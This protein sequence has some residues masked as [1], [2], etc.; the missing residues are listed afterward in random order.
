METTMTMDQIRITGYRVLLQELG[1]VNLARFLQQF[2]TG[3]GDYTQERHTWL[4]Q[5]TTVE[6]IAQEI[7]ECHEDE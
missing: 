6:E 7:R 1:P 3:Y 5:Y 4:G 2:E